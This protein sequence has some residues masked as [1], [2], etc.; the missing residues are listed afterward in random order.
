[1]MKIRIGNIYKN[2]KNTAS[3]WWLM[4]PSFERYWGG[5]IIHIGTRAIYLILDFRNINSIE[6]FADAL[7]YP[8]VWNILKR[9]RK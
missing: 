2:M 7:K 1:M 9:F 5:Q 3:F 8:K 4:T 6:D